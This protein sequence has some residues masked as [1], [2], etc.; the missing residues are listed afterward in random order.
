M[1]PNTTQTVFH[2]PSGVAVHTTAEA[3]QHTAKMHPDRV[4]LRTPGGVQ[5]ITWREYA[6]RVES[7]ALGLVSLGVKR[8]DTVGLMLTN[9][10]EFH[11]VDTAIVHLGAIP[12]SV[13]NT[14]APEQLAYL[15]G[16]AANRIV[17][18]EQVFLPAIRASG[19]ELEHIIT[20]DGPAEG[21]IELRAVETD[22]DTEFDFQA[23]WRAVEPDD[24]VTLIY[25]SGTTGPPKGVEITHRNVIAAAESVSADLDTGFD[26]RIISYL[27]AAHIADRVS[28]HGANQLRGIQI[29][30][31]ADPREFAAALPDVRPTVFFGVPRVWQKIKAGIEAKVAEETSPVKSKL[32]AWA[33]DV[34]ARAARTDLSGRPRGRALQVQYQL[35]DRLVLSKVRA[36]LGLDELKLAISGAASIPA[37]VIEFFV[38]LGIPVIEV[39]G[40]SETTGAATKTTVDNLKVGTVGKPVEGVEIKLAE[41]GEVLVRAPIVMRG[42]RNKPDKTAD[43]IDADGWFATGDVGTIDAEGNLTIV[44]RKKELIINESGKNMAPS[45]I[46][47]AVKANSSLASQVVAVGDDKPY[48]T[49]LIVLD[50]DVVALRAKALGI[51]DAQIADLA[52]NPEI[53]DEVTLSVKAG[54]ARLSRVEQVKRF[55]IVPEAWDPGGDELTPTMKLRRKPIASKYAQTILD[56]YS[57]PAGQGVVDLGI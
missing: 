31:V 42:Y 26:D 23:S 57:T 6:A 36:A 51:P 13:Y 27:P 32:A 54:N 20:V 25:T 1:N 47:N 37:E 29:T 44:D 56:L 45:T 5:E 11:L 24:L 2:H 40:L 12:F 55:V 22:P 33:L 30:S 21:A 14:S 41:D 52:A 46:E 49:A 43:A 48:I 7:I 34:A 9:R 18:T 10:P 15:F 53:I 19:A 28:S 17:V 38:G 39:W 16:D 35:A 50:P 3:F 8:G 4:A